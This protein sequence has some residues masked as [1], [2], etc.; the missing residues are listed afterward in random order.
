MKAWKKLLLG[1][2]AA[3]GISTSASS[4]IVT[5]FVF[6]VDESGSMGTVQANLRDK[7]GD[8][9]TILSDGGVDARYALVGFGASSQGT[10]PRLITDLTSAA[11]F[12]T[13]AQGLIASGGTEPGY[14]ASAFALNQIDG[15]TNTI[16][17][18][19]N[20]LINLVMFSD[21]P[22][23]GDG[24]YGLVGGLAPTGAIVDSLVKADNALYNAVV[25]FGGAGGSAA[26]GYADLA[27][28]NGGQVFNLG[29]FA[30]SNDAQTQ[31]FVKDFAAA[32]LQEIQDFCD[33]NPNDPACTG[34]QVPV[35]GTLLLLGLGLI[36][37][38][39][40]QMMA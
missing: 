19:N 39:V 14:T 22:S 36:G 33:L 23:N 28:D 32:K 1:T 38:R 30:T 31:A 4:A 34:G 5:D 37:L 15:Q 6:M 7:I 8:F 40:R 27:N 2:V 25:S 11:S 21:E 13:A 16:S 12:A 10:G 24:S 20:S 17:F 35:P 3:F 26:N 29:D 9:A 18:R